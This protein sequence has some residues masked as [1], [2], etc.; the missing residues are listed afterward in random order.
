MTDVCPHGRPW[1]DCYEDGGH[2]TFASGDGSGIPGPLGHPNVAFCKCGSAWFNAVVCFEQDGLV[3][4]WAKVA[5]ADCGDEKDPM[6][7]GDHPFQFTTEDW[8]EKRRLV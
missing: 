2:P 1:D 6:F 4:G 7:K 5:C 3:T 8:R